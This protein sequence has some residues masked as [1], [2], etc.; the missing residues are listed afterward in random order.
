MK[1]CVKKVYCLTCQ[2]LV[3]CK[4]QTAANATRFVCS[5]C[6]A[7]VWTKEGTQWKHASKLA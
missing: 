1:L 7:T 5:R 4:E 2:K 3:N 6:G